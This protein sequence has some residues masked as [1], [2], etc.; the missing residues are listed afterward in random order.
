[1]A[2]NKLTIITPTYNRGYI[3]G[4]L[5]ESLCRQTINRFEWIIVDDGSTDDTQDI[6]TS[7]I[8]NNV[9]FEIQYIKQ[10]N[11]GKHRALNK[12]ITYAQYNYIYII[13]SDDYMTDDAVEMIYKWIDT[14]DGNDSFAGVSGLR[15][16]K[17][18][19]I[20]G[21]FPNGKDY[22]DATNL[23]R[24]KY[25]LLGDKAEVYKRDLLL[26]YKFPE[27]D[28]EKFLSEGA[29]WNKIAGDG[30]KIRWFGEIICICE[31]LEDGLSQNLSK[32]VLLNNFEGYAYNEKLKVH[33]AVFPDNLLAIS[34]FIDLAEQ[35]GLS[36]SEIKAKL[37]ISN[38]ILLFGI[39]TGAL[40]KFMKR[41]LRYDN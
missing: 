38:P 11:G 18:N 31:Y 41:V 33:L 40:R 24:K 8:S 2:D 21:Q 6:V 17:D 7:W 3:L 35:K 4:V 9:D 37:N 32:Q 25:K 1:M 12:G 10:S 19:T 26:K 20:I 15:G 28:N 36:L 27:F 13:D 30:Y 23:E 16:H 34:R 22:I 29:V 39:F 14:I 5:F